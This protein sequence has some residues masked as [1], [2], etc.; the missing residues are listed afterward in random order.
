MVPIFPIFEY[1]VFEI[2]IGI[3]DIFLRFRA[4][5]R[6][7][8]GVASGRATRPGPRALREIPRMQ[9]VVFGCLFRY[10]RNV[11]GKNGGQIRNQH[12]KLA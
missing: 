8:V 1:S 7:P 12:E 10:E 3:L 9:A 11:L 5:A 2:L 6:Q 4:R